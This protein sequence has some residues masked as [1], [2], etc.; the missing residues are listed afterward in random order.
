[1][2]EAPQ[3]DTQLT[4]TRCRPHTSCVCEAALV[5]VLR[6]Y[7]VSDVLLACVPELP[8]PVGSAFLGVSI[9]TVPEAV[10][11]AE[12]DLVQREALDLN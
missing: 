12:I 10:L 11:A 3:R 6:W 7:W 9:L 1:L 2:D 5:I 8:P 4:R